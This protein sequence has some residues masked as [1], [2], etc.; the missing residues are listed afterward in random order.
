M[1][2]KFPTVHY[3]VSSSEINISAIDA[4]EVWQNTQNTINSV[5]GYYNRMIVE[6]AGNLL[7]ALTCCTY[8]ASYKKRFTSV[9]FLAAIGTEKASF[10]LT[11]CKNLEA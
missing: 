10:I 2:S 1:F 8:L 9:S 5:V 4:F 11:K 6:W 7:N 3:T